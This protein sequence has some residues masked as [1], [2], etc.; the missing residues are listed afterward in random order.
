MGAIEASARQ[1]AD[2]IGVID[3]I[4]F[5]TNL[6]ALNAGVE[7]ARAGDAG[8]G[9]AVVASEVR[10]L[11]Q[12][13]AAAARE[14]KSLIE[15]SNGHVAEGVDLV[16]RTGD[17]LTRIVGQVSAVT[18]VVGGIATSAR[19]QATGLRQI[20]SAINEMDSVTQ[21]NAAMVE[22]STA[23][24]HGLLGD[25]QAL[26]DLVARFNIGQQ[27]GHPNAA[28][29]LRPQPAQRSASKRDSYNSAAA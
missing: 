28:R 14:I 16:H 5:Q 17:T 21:R 1:M 27:A 29:G 20:N 18:D 7:A 24:S 6:L 12:R 11:A 13:S 8:R 15:T 2:I 26:G 9:F 19:E 3:E 22:Q 25:A 10:A 23:A 4:A